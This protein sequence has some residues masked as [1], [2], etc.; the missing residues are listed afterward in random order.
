V[1]SGFAV[2]L[3]QDRIGVGASL[4][5]Q[6]TETEHPADVANVAL[7]RVTSIL[8]SLSLCFDDKRANY[9]VDVPFV[10]HSIQ[11]LNGLV[12]EASAALEELYTVCDLSILTSQGEVTAL[13]EDA[14][15]TRM[16]FNAVM[17]HHESEQAKH[18]VG[19]PA[20]NDAPAASYEELLQKV[21][22]AEVFAQAQ[23][24]QIDGG[25]SSMLLP[26]LNSLKHDILRMRR[27][28]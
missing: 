11:A 27:I 14:D 25:E 22:A 28:A 10:A 8:N 26:I 18:D 2:M 24:S 6:D 13:A 7:Q 19:A 3:G 23:A 21:T 9:A 4:S 1:F 17:Q 12:G 16:D 5:D 15:G 20:L